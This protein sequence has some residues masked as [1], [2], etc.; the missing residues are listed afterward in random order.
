MHGELKIE[1]MMNIEGS[2]GLYKVG[3]LAGG[4]RR[5]DGSG[6]IMEKVGQQ[7]CWAE[8]TRH[9]LSRWSRRGLTDDDLQGC[10]GINDTRR[11]MRPG[12]EMLLEVSA[13]STDKD[14]RCRK[15]TP[16]DGGDPIS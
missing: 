11:G 2:Q 9:R 13:C 16:A 6:R 7:R 1:S 14:T 5:H 4:R 8:E 10:D 12:V 3:S 15:E